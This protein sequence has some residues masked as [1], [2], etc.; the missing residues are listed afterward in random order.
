MTYYICDK[1]EITEILWGELLGI[2]PKCPKQKDFENDCQVR[3]HV[4]CG[5][6]AAA[7]AARAATQKCLGIEIDGDTGDTVDGQNPAPPR[8]MIIPLFIGF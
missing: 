6:D 7:A 8:M 3:V 2:T 1:A 5:E 4:L